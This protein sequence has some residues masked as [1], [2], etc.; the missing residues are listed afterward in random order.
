MTDGRDDGR[1]RKTYSRKLKSTINCFS[2]SRLRRSHCLEDKTT[3]ND[4][5]NEV[6]YL[7]REQTC[8]L[9]ER[10]WKI[11][12]RTKK[13]KKK[14][15]IKTLELSCQCA[16]TMCHAPE[17]SS[18]H[19]GEWCHPVAL[20]QRQPSLHWP[21]R[22]GCRFHCL[23]LPFPWQRDRSWCNYTEAKEGKTSFWTTFENPLNFL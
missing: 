2:S 9:W 22:S 17:P 16:D 11:K 19:Q 5:H 8:Y 20:S 6:Y 7:K 21:R 4:F 1:D 15:T 14:S 12:K 13:E 23:P 10:K 18:I 3:V